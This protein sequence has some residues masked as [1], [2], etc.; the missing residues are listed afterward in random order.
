MHPKQIEA[1]RRMTPAEKLHLAARFMRDA[2]RL[3]AAGLRMLHPDWTA[4]EIAEAVRKA[5]LY[6][7]S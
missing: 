2:R 3:K 4:E 7:R 6:A 1:F 5:F